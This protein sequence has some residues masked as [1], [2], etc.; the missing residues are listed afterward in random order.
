MKVES[1]EPRTN[2]NECIDCKAF[3]SLILDHESEHGVY[4]RILI[5]D[6]MHGEIFARNRA[7]AIEMFRNNDY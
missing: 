2:L 1:I 3:A 7:E 6:L 5:E 4:C